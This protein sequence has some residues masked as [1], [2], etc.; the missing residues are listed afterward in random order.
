[1]EK[2]VGFWRAGAA[3]STAGSLV[4]AFEYGCSDDEGYNQTRVSDIIANAVR[5]S[6][7]E[8]VKVVGSA[9]DDEYQIIVDHRSDHVDDDGITVGAIH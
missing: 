7:T 5:V 8:G 3:S 2:A 6:R 9:C 1:L 4:A